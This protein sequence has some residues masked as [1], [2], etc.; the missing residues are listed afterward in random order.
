MEYLTQEEQD[1]IKFLKE[2]I[3]LNIFELGKVEI[4]IQNLLESKH[5]LEANKQNLVSTLNKLSDNET[6]F[7][8]IL[9][10]KYGEKHIDLKTF[11]VK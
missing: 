11:E 2:G 3:T 7:I 5:T 4:D 1:K 6:E 8:N 9:H 10:D